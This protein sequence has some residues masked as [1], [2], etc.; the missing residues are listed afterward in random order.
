M[1]IP[2]KVHQ[3][4]WRR[5]CF[6][7]SGEVCGWHSGLWCISG[8][9]CWCTIF[10]A[11]MGP[12]W[13]PQKARRDTELVF[14]HPLWSAC[15]VVH[16]SASRAWKVAALFFILGWARCGSHKK[17]SKITLRWTCAF[18]SDRIYGSH[19]AFLCVWGKKHQRTIF[20][21]HVGPVW[22]SQKTVA[23][24]TSNLCFCTIGICWYVVHSGASGSQTSTPYFSSLGRPGTDPTKSRSGHITLNLCFCILYDLWVT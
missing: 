20:Y 18:A 12:V 10:H 8:V 13:I 1:R 15:H 16:S 24:I 4:T 7:A 6:F 2:Q 9:K 23:H 17:H 14:L 19:N 11:R 21:A 22:I 5:I 3:D